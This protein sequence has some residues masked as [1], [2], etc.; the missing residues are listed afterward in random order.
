MKPAVKVLVIIAA[1]IGIIWAIV[2]FFGVAIGGGFVAAF[3]ETK[4]AAQKTVETS[5]VI[6]M[7]LA[8]SFIAIVAGLIFGII[9]AGQ[10][11][12]RIAGIVLSALLIICGVAATMWA[13]YVAGPLYCLCGILALIANAAAKARMAEEKR[14]G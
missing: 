10:E 6:M 9:S 12:N 1:V 7:K 13:S 5:A 8:G 11:V 3:K 14:N 4:E 2:G